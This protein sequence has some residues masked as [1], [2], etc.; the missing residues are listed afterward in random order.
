MCVI[1]IWILFD[2]LDEISDVFLVGFVPIICYDYEAVGH[3][4]H[5]NRILLYH[6]TY[7]FGS[8]GNRV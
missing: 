5:G 1:L 2:V 8:I 4:S 6:S 7:F 3:W